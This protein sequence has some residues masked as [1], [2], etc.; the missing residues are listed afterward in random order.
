[1]VCHTNLSASFTPTVTPRPTQVTHKET[2]ARSVTSS[3]ALDTPT[4]LYKS[5]VTRSHAKLLQQE[6]HAFLSGLHSNI[7]ENYIAPKS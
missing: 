1:M 4:Q 2:S 7:E 6:L 3:Q 5:L